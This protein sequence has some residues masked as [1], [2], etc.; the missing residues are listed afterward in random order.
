MLLQPPQVVLVEL[1]NT[2][3]LRCPFCTTSLAMRR[4]RGFMPA[5]LFRQ[6]IEELAE[7]GCRPLISMNMCGEPLLHRRVDKFVGLAAG[8]GFPTFISTNA[9][10]LTRRLAERLAAAG[11]SS[12]ALCVDGATA[13][14]HEAYRVGSDFRRVRANCESMLDA[15]ARLA[16][17]GLR[18]SIQTLL[19]ARSETEMPQVLDWAWRIGADEVYFKSLSVGTC[20][21]AAQRQSGAHLMPRNPALRRRLSPSP[22][23]CAAPVCQTMVYFDG[24]LG[25]CCVD[26]NNLAGLPSIRRRGLFDTL[27]GREALAARR[28]GYHREHAL[29]RDCQ[30]SGSTFRGFR[31]AL[32]EL[33][34]GGESRPDW[35]SLIAGKLEETTGHAVG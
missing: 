8:C 20:T 12:I 11:L 6:L 16:A 9:T 24:R 10:R 32:D 34:A 19:T 15:R 3:N 14:A 7:R 22:S 29:C 30:S 31:V 27:F 23:P 13:A 1:T 26:F 4:P 2:C 33:R 35:T 17:S 18:V 28:S 21:T 25:I 5:A